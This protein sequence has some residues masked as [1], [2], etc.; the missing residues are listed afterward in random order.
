MIRKHILLGGDMD[1]F[2]VDYQPAQ[3]QGFAAPEAYAN[4]ASYFGIRKLIYEI[5]RYGRA[6]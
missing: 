6:I 5:I 2:L 1:R 4:V 3:D